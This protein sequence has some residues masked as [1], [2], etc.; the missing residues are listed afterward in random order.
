MDTAMTGTPEDKV[1]IG[2]KSETL[3]ERWGR[4]DGGF[5]EW[6]EDT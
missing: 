5:R 4:K 3:D 2:P 6:M 1:G